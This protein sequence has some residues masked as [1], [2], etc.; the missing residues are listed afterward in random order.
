MSHYIA[1]AAI[2]TIGFVYANIIYRRAQTID[3]IL[4]I[5]MYIAAMRGQTN[6]NAGTKV[7]NETIAPTQAAI[8]TKPND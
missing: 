8:L 3:G 2:L 1:S 7:K 5:E 4:P 6:S